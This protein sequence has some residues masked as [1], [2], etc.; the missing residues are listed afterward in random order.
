M[1]LTL[2]FH[3]FYQCLATIA[4]VYWRSDEESAESDRPVQTPTREYSDRILSNSRVDKIQQRKLKKIANKL[5]G[6]RRWKRLCLTMSF[7]SSFVDY[8]QLQSDALPAE[9]VDNPNAQ[10]CLRGIRSQLNAGYGTGIDGG[11]SQR[12]CCSLNYCCHFGNFYHYYKEKK[13]GEPADK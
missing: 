10:R 3:S 5:V 7:V 9:T 13:T 11:L 4:S 12:Q 6:N 1:D 8:S 2:S